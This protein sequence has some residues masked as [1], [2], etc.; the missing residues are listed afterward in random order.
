VVR[1][2]AFTLIE[3]IF[4]IVIIGI[5]VISLPR[6]T[7]VTSSGIEGNL[8]QEAIF[9]ASAQLN[10]AVAANWD[11]RSL[12][13][14]GAFSLARVVDDGN[15]N[16]NSADP[17]YRLKNG[18]I[19]QPMHRRCLDSNATGG[20][21]LSVT[22]VEALEDYAGT[23]TLVNAGAT[24]SGYKYEYSTVIAVTQN[25]NFNGAN[26]N[27]KMIEASIFESGN[28]LTSLR[29]YSANVGEVDYHKRTY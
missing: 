11:E 3:L 1:R 10:Q 20:K 15:C 7:Q 24:Q 9:A 16:N 22:N 14:G 8:V 26:A 12:E 27:I 23:K 21:G 5:S 13:D 17:R 18:H 25:A 19:L 2:F 6:M 4:A 29:T 28:L